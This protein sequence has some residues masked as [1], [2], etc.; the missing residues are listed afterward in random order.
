MNTPQP[1]QIKVKSACL[2]ILY[3]LISM[4][5]GCNKDSEDPLPSQQILGKWTISTTTMDLFLDNKA[6][7]QYLVDEFA[8]SQQEAEDFTNMLRDSLLEFFTGTITFKDN[9]TY[10]TDL[11]GDP[12]SGTWSLS[13]D[14]KT[15][16]L[17]EGTIDET[18]ITIVTLNSSTLKIT[19]TQ[20]DAEDLDEDGISEVISVEISMTLNK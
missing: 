19:M 17:D 6:L 14:G 1:T 16:L 4:L 13:A 3:L 7:T 5:S 18:E 11:G 12:D 2:L 9:N 10:Q 8:V 20:E 15:L